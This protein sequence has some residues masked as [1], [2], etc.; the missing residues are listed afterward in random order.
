MRET[1]VQLGGKELEGNILRKLGKGWNVGFQGDSCTWSETWVWGSAGAMQEVDKE[2]KESKVAEASL[3]NKEAKSEK[4]PE[5][6]KM[7]FRAEG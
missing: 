5:T 6:L 4:G 7:R 1:F 2:D 3:V